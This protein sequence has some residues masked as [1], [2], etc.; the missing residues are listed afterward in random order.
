MLPIKSMTALSELYEL[1]SGAHSNLEC[2]SVKIF[3]QTNLIIN[4]LTIGFEIKMKLRAIL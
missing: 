1:F 4:S 3:F 2:V